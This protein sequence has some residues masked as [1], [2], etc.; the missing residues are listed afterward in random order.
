MNNIDN[1]DNNSTK[2]LVAFRPA[3]DDDTPFILNSWLKSYR[4]GVC[5]QHV[6]NEIYYKYQHKIIE[7]LLLDATVT[8]AV[9]LEDSTQII[10]YIATTQPFLCHYIYV[11][12]PFRK[13][14]IAEQL[15]NGANRPQICTHLPRGFPILKEKHNLVFNPFWRTDK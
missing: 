8:V 9:S 10:G 11:K 5:S 13:L 12:Y 15:Y 6:P 14:G 7:N 3:N 2:S 4:N 1:I